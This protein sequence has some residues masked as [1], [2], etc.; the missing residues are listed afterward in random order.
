LVLYAQNYGKMV[1]NALFLAFIVWIVTF[2]IF[3]LV[4]AP[5]AALV[6][7]FPGIAG[8]CTMVIAIVVAISLKAAIVDPLAMAALIQAYFKVTDG[9]Q[10]NPEWVQ[11]LEGVSDKFKELG[12]KARSFVPLKTAPATVPQPTPNDPANP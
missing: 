6:A 4:L 8:F 5:V 3:L 10:P 2:V 1:K 9:Q 12:A 7:L 11:K